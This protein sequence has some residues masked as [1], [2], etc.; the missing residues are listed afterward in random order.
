LPQCGNYPLPDAPVNVI[1]LMKRIEVRPQVAQ[2]LGSI[3]N[4]DSFVQ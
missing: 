1:D 4:L 3:G 2:G